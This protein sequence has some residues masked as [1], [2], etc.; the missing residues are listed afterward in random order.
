L[1]EIKKWETHWFELK[2]E[3]LFKLKDELLI[4]L[5]KEARDKA[6]NLNKLVKA[7]SLSYPSFLYALQ[8]RA[9]LVS[10][11]K[12]KKLA[13]FL[14]LE[15]SYFNDKIIE[16]KKGRIASIKNPKFP[17]NLKCKE[18]AYLLGCV[19]SDGGIYIDKRSRNVKRTAYY[20]SDKESINNFI[21]CLNKVF[22]KV[23]IINS[24]KGKNIALG[25]KSSIIGDSLAKV[26]AIVGNKTKNNEC[27]PWIVKEYPEISDN[28]FNAIF[29]DEGSVGHSRNFPYI[30]LTRY[31]HLTSILSSENANELNKKIKPLMKERKFSTG[32]KIK[33]IKFSKVRELASKKL[34]KKIENKGISKLLLDESEL[35][36]KKGLRKRIWLSRLG[37]TGK[38]HYTTATSIFINRKESVLKFYKEIGFSLSRKQ[39]KLKHHLMK[40]GRISETKTL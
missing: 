2:E 10:V 30:T 32:H 26:G 20:S 13:D 33:S 19:V 37:L 14:E 34:V 18:G 24:T 12:L 29:G 22:G 28:Y 38:G 15:Y 1:K 8:R 25:I 40:V 11:R 16:V 39:D 23:H 7:L 31:N 4:E 17:F 27:I 9:K 36:E 21:R 3:S 6:G 5:I 35:L